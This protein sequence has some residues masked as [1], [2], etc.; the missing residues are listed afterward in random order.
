MRQCLVEIVSKV[1]TIT[2]SRDKRINVIQSMVDTT[3]NP[4]LMCRLVLWGLSGR[5][6]NKF[7]TKIS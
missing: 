4:P 5:S 7:G 1:L 6:I 3:E 2:S